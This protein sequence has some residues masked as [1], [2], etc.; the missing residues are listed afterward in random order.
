MDGTGYQ[1]META[2]LEG[3]EP[4]ESS[5]GGRPQWDRR[6]TA[7]RIGEHA[8]WRSGGLRSPSAVSRKIEYCEHLRWEGR[9]KNTKPQ[10]GTPIVPWLARMWQRALRAPGSATQPTCCPQGQSPSQ[11]CRK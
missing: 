4:L 11:L 6:V 5:G 9:G 7:V 2:V 8:A 10:G 1:T 3:A